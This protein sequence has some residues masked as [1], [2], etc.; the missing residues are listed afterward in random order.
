MTI[1]AIAPSLASALPSLASS[2]PAAQA[3]SASAGQANVVQERVTLSSMSQ[4]ATSN[5]RTVNAQTYSAQGLLQQI[6]NTFL[7]GETGLQ[8]DGTISSSV[9]ADLGTAP[10]TNDASA[11]ISSSSNLAQLLKQNP[12]YAGFLVQSQMND[13]LMTALGSGG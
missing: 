1:N 9:T 7:N 4:G 11:N 12:A 3:A 13:S 6:Q 8:S 5:G 2:Q 10:S